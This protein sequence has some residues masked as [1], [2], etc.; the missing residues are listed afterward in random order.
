MMAKRYNSKTQKNRAKRKEL[1]DKNL[2]NLLNF[3]IIISKYGKVS[4]TVYNKLCGT[5][6]V[7]SHS[8]LTRHRMSYQIFVFP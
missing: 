2:K 4:T 3:A 1:K 7:Y 8:V 6:P 5:V